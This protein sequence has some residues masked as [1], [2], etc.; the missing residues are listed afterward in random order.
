MAQLK[1]LGRGLALILLLGGMV[2]AWRHH[3]I[4]DPTA[5]AGWVASHP[6]APIAFLALHVAASLI[7]IPRTV[8][9]MAAG[10]L[11]GPGWGLLLATL[12]SV[13]GAVAGFLLARYV[14]SGLI[15]PEAMPHLGP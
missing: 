12:G 13:L 8:M 9:A 1:G 15:D 6:A 5:M 10:A 2:L 7:F 3:A 11:F 4:F 14:N